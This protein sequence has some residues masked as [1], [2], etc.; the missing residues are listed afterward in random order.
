M[1]RQHASQLTGSDPLGDVEFRKKMPLLFA[2]Y[3]NDLFQPKP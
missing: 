2:D 3:D 1:N